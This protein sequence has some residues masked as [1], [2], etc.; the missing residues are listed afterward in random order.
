MKEKYDQK[1][2]RKTEDRERQTLEPSTE[3][4]KNKQRKQRQGVYRV[5][6]MEMTG[7]MGGI[8]LVNPCEKDTSNVRVIVVNQSS[9]QDLNSER[10]LY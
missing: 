4:D 5:V 1:K 3:K 10:S 9:S 6:C 8:L 7:A 2:K